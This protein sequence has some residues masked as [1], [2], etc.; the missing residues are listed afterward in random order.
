MKAVLAIGLLLVSTPLSAQTIFPLPAAPGPYLRGIPEGTPTTEVLRLSMLDAINRGLQHNLGLLNADQE[1]GRAQGARLTALAD[2]L[3]NVTGRV[4]ETRQRLNLA[5]FGFPLPAGVPP[6]VG[7][8]NV[9]DARLRLSQAVF[10]GH[11]LNTLRSETHSLA[12]AEYDIKNARDL[13]VLVT[14]NLYLQAI[15]G[16]A[17]AETARAQAATADAIFQQATNM[18]ASG[19]VAGIDVLRAEVQLAAERQRTTAAYNTAEKAKLQLARIIGLAP[20]QPFELIDQLPTLPAPQITFE[21]ALDRAYKTRPDYQAALERVKASESARQAIVGEALPSFRIDADYGALGLTPADAANTYAVA[22]SVSV[23]IFQGGRTRGKLQEADAELRQLQ[24]TAEDLRGG[25]YY[26][27]KNAFLD[28][29]STRE[30]VDVATRARE[31]ASQQ[32]TQA[33]DRLAAGVA[34]TVEVVQAQDAVAQANERYIDALY[35]YNVANALLAR[36]ISG[37][38]DA[39]RQYLGGTR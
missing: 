24:L 15:A 4:T 35:G 30:Q 1:V 3:P 25:I 32:L 19:I 10:D 33:R 21:D 13:V 28:L 6:L 26:D 39:V 9:F 34:D 11:A 2:L 38:E 27:I 29:T 22:G 31:L 37:A 16:A 20:G 36:G 18:K 23:P 7:P 12:A 17:R 14:A 8:F 5:V